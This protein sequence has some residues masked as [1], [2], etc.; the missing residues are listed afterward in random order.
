MLQARTQLDGTMGIS[1]RNF[2][3]GKILTYGANVV[4]RTERVRS[5]HQ[6]ATFGWVL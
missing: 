2:H 1:K 4:E 3:D 6:N 5:A